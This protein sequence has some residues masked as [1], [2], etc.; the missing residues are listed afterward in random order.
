MPAK[1]AL[2]LVLP[3]AFGLGGVACTGYVMPNDGAGPAPVGHATTADSGARSTPAIGNDLAPTPPLATSGSATTL[4][5]WAGSIGSWCGPFETQTL[6]LT[7][8]PQASV[9]QAAAT[10]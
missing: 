8:K 1:K 2:V 4:A 9:C 3:A 10:K 5:P 7:G 6:W